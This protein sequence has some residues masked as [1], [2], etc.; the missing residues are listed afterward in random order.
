MGGQDAA[1][2]WRETPAAHSFPIDL[3]RAGE[4]LGQSDWLIVDHEMITDFGIATR[5]PDPMH[6]DPEWARSGPF[7]T[8]IAFGFLTIALLTHFLRNALSR[9]PGA[10]SHPEVRHLDYGF[11]RI[12]LIEPV[13]EGSRLR[14]HFIVRE[15][16]DAAGRRLACLD[17][18]IEIEGNVRPALVAE[19]L[20]MG[21]KSPTV[22][23]VEASQL[24]LN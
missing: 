22:R 6:M 16:R 10:G 3:W 21:L 9:A 12:R 2:P 18:K 15:I 19:W 14:A 7:G 17:C 8:T 11:D 24:D 5:D 23:A 1:Q 13:R 20:I 4:S